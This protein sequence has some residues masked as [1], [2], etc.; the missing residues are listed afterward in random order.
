[1]R[2]VEFAG[3]KFLEHGSKIKGFFSR[4]ACNIQ[5]KFSKGFIIKPKQTHKRQDNKADTRFVNLDDVHLAIGRIDT[6]GG[7]ASGFIAVR[8]EAIGDDFEFHVCALKGDGSVVTYPLSKEA[9]EEMRRLFEIGVP[10][11]G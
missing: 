10:F 9:K 3:L 8:R 4:T 5:R 7:D 2:L 11:D 1:M 6:Y